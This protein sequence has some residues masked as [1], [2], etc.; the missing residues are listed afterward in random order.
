MFPSPTLLLP[1]CRSVGSPP[2]PSPGISN[3]DTSIGSFTRAPLCHIASRQDSLSP[4]RGAV[5]IHQICS[6]PA[7]VS[8][9]RRS[10]SGGGSGAADCH[11]LCRKARSPVHGQ[12]N[13]PHRGP[14]VL[15]NK[16]RFGTNPVRAR[17]RST[18]RLKPAH[19]RAQSLGD[20]RYRR[21]R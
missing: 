20:G 12:C 8:S 21:L 15:C 19:P 2:R 17:K 13:T 5:L 1:S 18:R 3:R 10:F 14:E 9:R 11:A 4:L 7:H 16:N 6:L